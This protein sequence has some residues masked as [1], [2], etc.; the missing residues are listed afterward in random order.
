MFR[1]YLNSLVFSLLA[2]YQ[3]A[4]N[5]VRKAVSVGDV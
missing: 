2:T 3:V 5:L 4:Q 1:I